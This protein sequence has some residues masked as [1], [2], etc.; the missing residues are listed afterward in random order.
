MDEIG[1]G[2]ACRLD[3]PRPGPPTGRE[4]SSRRRQNWRLPWLRRGA[5]GL[6]RAGEHPSLYLPLDHAL[7]PMAVLEGSR[8]D[9]SSRETRRFGLAA[10][11][12]TPGDAESVAAGLA[13]IIEQGV[14]VVVAMGWRRGGG[15]CRQNPGRC[16]PCTW[17]AGFDLGWR[18][19]RRLGWH[20]QRLR[21][22]QLRC[23]RAGRTGDRRQAEG[24][25]PGHTAT[26]CDGERHCVRRPG[27][28]VT[29]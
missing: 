18:V 23:G 12:A 8:P 26:Y 3:R 7:A 13:R 22:P 4:M 5:L 11:M 27:S 2:T 28:P 1:P 17:A 20:P 15:P 21:R 9:N 16:R 29:M 24:A 10:S 19:G 25:S 6:P 14:Q